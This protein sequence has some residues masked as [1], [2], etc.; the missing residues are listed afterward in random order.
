[1]S[2]GI[3]TTSP[4]SASWHSK[5]LIYPGQW[6]LAKS[7]SQ[8]GCHLHKWSV[9]EAKKGTLEFSQPCVAIRY[10]RATPFFSRGVRLCDLVPVKL[11]GGHPLREIVCS[12]HIPG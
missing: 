6:C 11:W 3:S 9:S 5:P 10:R 4:R 8:E 7:S 12:G 2:L 1:V